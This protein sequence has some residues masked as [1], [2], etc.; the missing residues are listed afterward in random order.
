M[1]TE[2]FAYR[3]ADVPMWDHF[4][5]RSRRLLVQSFRVV[6]EQVFPYYAGGK[7]VSG[8]EDL[9]DELNKLLAMEL[10][11]KDLSDPTYGYYGDWNGKKHW[12]SGSWPKVKVCED[13]VCAEYDDSVAPDQFIKERLSFAEIALRRKAGKLLLQEESLKLQGQKMEFHPSGKIKPVH[14]TGSGSDFFMKQ[15]E[16]EKSAFAAS[17]DE[18]NARLRQAG[19]N[20][21]YH[22][23]Y[24]QL[25]AD[26]TTHELI[27]KPFWRL[28]SGSKW[29]NVDHDMKEAVDLR[30]TRGRD[31][32]WYAA[33]A[34][35]STVKIISDDKGWSTGTEKGAGNYL[36]NLRAKKN[37]EFINGWEHKNLIDFFSTVRNPFGHGAGSEKMPSLT[38]YQTDWAIEFAMIWIK[39]LIRR[40]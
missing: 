11:L 10:G 31:P 24:I 1:L 14:R 16:H 36:D 29:H 20:L 26:E 12:Y 32:A 22:N 25:Y 40:L 3:Y 17:C 15:L 38:A 30:D 28:V 27:E 37:G 8:M 21:H 6:S 23:G 19:T 18:L 34:L 9:W 35:E 5:E 13:F 4:D 39:N 7:T 2:I 33:K